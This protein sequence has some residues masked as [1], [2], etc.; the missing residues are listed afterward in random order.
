MKSETYITLLKSFLEGSIIFGIFISKVDFISNVI[1]NGNGYEQSALI[2]FGQI[3]ATLIMLILTQ[4]WDFFSTKLSLD[5]NIENKIQKTNVTNCYF[6]NQNNKTSKPELE[7]NIL[8]NINYKSK[9]SNKMILDY[10]KNRK[11]SFSVPGNDYVFLECSDGEII[12]IDTLKGFDIPLEDLLKEYLE[13]DN[14]FFIPKRISAKLIF[15]PL[16]NNSVDILSPINTTKF[17][18]CSVIN[19]NQEITF[20][21][22]INEKFFTKITIS[23]HTLNVCIEKE[24][25]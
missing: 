24:G 15:N 9:L 14:N 7:I 21:D 22:F 11:I 3:A 17:I 6:K 12:K 10:I 4:I 13:N 20:K 16:L 8:L 25:D 5:I 2:V 19:N 1:N 18:Y 23:K